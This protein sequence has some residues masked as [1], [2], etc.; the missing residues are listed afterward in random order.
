MSMIKLK[1]KN[2]TYK[3]L[4]KKYSII[5]EDDLNIDFNADNRHF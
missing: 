5:E 4:Q 2:P 1:L 3:E